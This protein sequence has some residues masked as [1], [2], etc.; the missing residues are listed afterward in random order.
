MI[1][2]IFFGER[3]I[4]DKLFVDK[5]IFVLLLSEIILMILLLGEDIFTYLV[6]LFLVVIVIIFDWLMFEVVIW[7]VCLIL[8]FI[9]RVSRRGS[10]GNSWSRFMNCLKN[11]LLI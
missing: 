6:L 10:F 8:N 2:I 3:A 4:L 11:G 7:E 1:F 9:F 5:G